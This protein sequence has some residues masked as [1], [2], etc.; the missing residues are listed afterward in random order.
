MEVEGIPTMMDKWLKKTTP[1]DNGLTRPPD[2]TCFSVHKNEVRSIG[3]RKI[4]KNSP[5]WQGD[6]VQ[7]K[8]GFQ[9]G[10]EQVEVYTVSTPAP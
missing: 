2:S 6:R 10:N 7:R 5:K 4:E 9:W 1:G 3:D 8:L